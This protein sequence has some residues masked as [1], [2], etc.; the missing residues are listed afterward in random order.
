MKELFAADAAAA[1]VDDDDA[2]IAD[3]ETSKM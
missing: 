1:A 2:P 3:D